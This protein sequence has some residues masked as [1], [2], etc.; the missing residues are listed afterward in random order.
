[1]NKSCKALL[2]GVGIAAVLGIVSVSC[3]PILSARRPR[4]PQGGTT[5]ARNL[6]QICMGA[7]LYAEKHDGQFPPGFQ[8]MVPEYI[9]NPKVFRC[10]W[11]PADS[12]SYRDFLPGGHVTE[13][14]T[15]FAY[16]TGLA[17]A[18]PGKMIVAYDK[19]LDNHDKPGRYVVNLD[20]KAEWWPA[21]RENEFQQRLR[22]QRAAILNWRKA[23]ARRE[24][25]EKFFKEFGGANWWERYGKAEFGSSE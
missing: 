3:F 13:K 23:G 17:N 10:P 12:V 8:A 22:I 6:Q 11:T 16:E 2:W 21:A 25:M 1:M 20:A 14:S 9:D 4:P 18:M 24:D 15:S 7:F 19:S 5:C